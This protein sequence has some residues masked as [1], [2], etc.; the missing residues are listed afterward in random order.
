M[1]I[2]DSLPHLQQPTTCPYPSQINPFLF[3]SHFRKARLLS[4]L[5]GLRTYQHRGNNCSLQQ[6]AKP[7]SRVTSSPPVVAHVL[8]DTTRLHATISVRTSTCVLNLY[9]LQ[10]KVSLSLSIYLSISIYL[11]SSENHHTNLHAHPHFPLQCPVIT[12]PLPAAR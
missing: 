7:H 9:F 2:G 11:R 12:P 5:V 8:L 10:S 6:V 3:A 4:F 1:G